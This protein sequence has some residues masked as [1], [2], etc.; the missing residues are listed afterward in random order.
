MKIRW[1]LVLLSH[2]IMSCAEV[3]LSE[4]GSH[5]RIVKNSPNG[6]KYIKEL[7]GRATNTGFSSFDDQLEEAKIDIKN[8]AAKAGANTVELTGSNFSLTANSL[9]GE[10]YDCP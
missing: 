7:T 8:K 4:E 9:K 1:Y 2:V 5:V 10:A 3:K 6:C